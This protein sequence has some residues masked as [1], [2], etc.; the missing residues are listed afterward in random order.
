[1]F[2]DSTNLALVAQKDGQ[3]A[4]LEALLR[5]QTDEAIGERTRARTRSDELMERREGRWKD[6]LE[7]GEAKWKKKLEKV[8]RKRR[9]ELKRFKEEANAKAAE[10]SVRFCVYVV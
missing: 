10:V 1:M 3:I 4:R 6:K 2:L 7:R 8:E 9:E 5:E